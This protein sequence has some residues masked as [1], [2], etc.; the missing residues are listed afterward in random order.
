MYA[1]ANFYKFPFDFGEDIVLYWIHM[2]FDRVIMFVHFFE[3]HLGFI[4]SHFNIISVASMQ[5]FS[6]VLIL[7]DIVVYDVIG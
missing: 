1:A 5:N 2:Y 3:W 7:C 6:P 4:I